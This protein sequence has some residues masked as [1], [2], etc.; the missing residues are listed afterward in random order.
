MPSA[1]RMNCVLWSLWSCCWHY[2]CLYQALT[3][4]PLQLTPNVGGPI[5]SDTT[6]T[7]ANSPYIVTSSVQV[8]TGVTLTIQ[9]GVVVKFNS[10][11]LLQVDGTLIARGTA[12]NLI[13]FTSNQSSPQQGDWGYIYFTDGSTDATF[14]GAGNYTGGS[15]LQYSIVEYGGGGVW[16]PNAA[17]HIDHCTVRNNIY[18]GIRATG[19]VTTPVVVGNNIVSGNTV[20][21]S[22]D[23]YGGGIYAEYGTVSGNT[24]S[25]NSAS[26]GGYDA[27]G[28]G[29]YAEY[30]TVSGNTVSGNSAT[31]HST[32]GGGIYAH[33]GTV[34][35][36]IVTGNS[37]GRK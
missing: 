16:A 12:A 34:T 23:A 29:I 37:A 11:K 26:A 10:A 21:A 4:A 31:G 7:L 9:A 36:N 8:M 33:G 2:L 27:Y 3:S 17:P 22:G 35:G 15:V 32:Y 25:G 24:V 19:T 1:I 28:G 30:S 18:G 6:W 5:I 14:D 20:T 13:S